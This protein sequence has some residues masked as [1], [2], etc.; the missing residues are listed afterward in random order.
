MS[1]IN[2]SVKDIMKFSKENKLGVVTGVNYRQNKMPAK[3]KSEFSYEEYS[4]DVEC[5]SPSGQKVVYTFSKHGLANIQ[6]GTNKKLYSLDSEERFSA[7]NPELHNLTVAFMKLLSNKSDISYLEEELAYRTKSYNNVDKKRANFAPLKS[8]Y[9]QQAIKQLEEF[10]ENSR[11]YKFTKTELDR[12]TDL[13][14][15]LSTLKLF[16]GRCIK[17]LEKQ[18]SSV[19]ENN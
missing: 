13:C 2:L 8:Y 6:I 5:T 1:L 11:I 16:Q 17:F 7:E 3:Y 9:N 14:N 4:L 15:S 10:G 18:I 12:Y 19:S